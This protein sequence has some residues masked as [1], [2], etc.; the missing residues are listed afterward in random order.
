MMKTPAGVHIRSNCYVMVAW[1]G[2]THSRTRGKQREVSVSTG[3]AVRRG[4]IQ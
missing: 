2:P 1:E 4:G 3:L